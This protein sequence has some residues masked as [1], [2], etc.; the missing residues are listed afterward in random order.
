MFPQG[1]QNF[2]IRRLAADDAQRLGAFYNSLSAQ[3]RLFFQP[4]SDTSAAGMQ[5]AVGRAAS[6][7]DLSLVA[8]DPAGDVF[9]HIFFADVAKERPHLGIGLRDEYQN[10]GLGAPLL[11]YLLALGR[12]VLSKKEVG[13][14][15]RKDNHR[16]FRLYRRLGFEIVRE[17]VT[18]REKDDSYEMRLAFH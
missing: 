17:D 11:A 10:L 16:A 2:S 1:Y 9:A 13:L 7:V 8:I 5:A 6:G 15:V 18:F 3:T 4:Y 12:H 14:T